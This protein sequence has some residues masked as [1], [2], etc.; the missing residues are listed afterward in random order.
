M[1]ISTLPAELI[2]HILS[3]IFPPEGWGKYWPLT[4]SVHDV[5]HFLDL[6]LV[7]KEFDMIVLDYFLTKEILAEDFDQAC[8]QRLDPPTPAAIRM[9]RRLLTR[10]IEREQ[11][12]DT[13]NPLVREIIAVVDAAV[14]HLQD[15]QPGRDDVEQLRETYTQGLVTAVIGFSGLSKTLLE[16]IVKGTKTRKSQAA[17]RRPGQRY[18]NLALTTAATLGRIEDMKFLMEKGAD[19][20]FDERGEWIGTPLYGAAIGG[21]IDAINILVNQ[22]GDD[23][24]RDSRYS[25]HTPLHY[26]ALN[27]HEKLVQWL[28]KH[29]AR[30]DER[31]YSDQTPLFCA[32]SSGYAGIV[33]ELLDFDR[34]QSEE[35]MAEPPQN[36]GD[37]AYH[38]G[39]VDWIRTNIE[40]I[41]LI[42]VDAE[43][44]RER[45]PLIMAVQRGY[46][47][48]VEELMGREDLNINRCNAEEYDMSPLATAASR[49]YEEIFRL[50]L[51]HP[52]VQKSI[53]DSSGHGI[54]K[55]AA[56]GGNPNIVREVLKWPNVD[57]NLRG[58]DDSTPIMWAALYGHESIVRIL[59]DEGA[60]VD[61]F[62]S[63]LHLQLMRLLGPDPTEVAPSIELLNA[64][65]G[66]TAVLVGSSALDAAV[67]GG[68][69]G[70]V[71]VLMEHPDVQ[72]DQYDFDDRT[73]F[74]NAALTGHAGVVKLLLA[75]GG[76]A[77]EWSRDMTGCTPLI[78]AARAGNE[79]VIKILLGHSDDP[80]NCTDCEGYSALV[81]AAKAGHKGVVDLLLKHPKIEVDCALVAAASENHK[82]IVRMLL[83]R[84]VVKSKR[85]IQRALLATEESRLDEMHAFLIPYLQT[86]PEE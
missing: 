58:A 29:N 85:E 43:D 10:Q 53:R 3:L 7:C 11:A 31:N 76:A 17:L 34:E 70:T 32:A 50:I 6:R 24:N 46:L 73:P 20:L 51:S 28:L 71:K 18:L 60:A 66:R 81:H 27:G 9:G 23:L 25:G 30:P 39:Y 48:T 36:E 86:M 13:G 1:P 45:T 2:Y 77:N 15:S 61:L 52:S 22:A 83:D 84:N 5:K 35:F 41:S 80:L 42:D 57:V 37:M 55:H 72:L 14:S 65:T 33:K 54:L 79:D 67:H 68:H 47:E 21:H 63:Q 40:G 12:R 16:G 56:A 26:A 69:E 64:M 74:A 4:R 62:T 19:P 8:L 75:R 59:I 38:N 82:A 78:L 44:S 49:G